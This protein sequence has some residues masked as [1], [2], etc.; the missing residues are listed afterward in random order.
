MCSI[1]SRMGFDMLMLVIL[2]FF[3]PSLVW[4]Y[5][6]N[7]TLVPCSTVP[8]IINS[9]CS[10]QMQT[11]SLSEI[12]LLRREQAPSLAD[13]FTSGGWGM[14]WCSGPVIYR[15]RRIYVQELKVLNK[16]IIIWK[17]Y[18]ILFIY[19][20]SDSTNFSYLLFSDQGVAEDCFSTS[21][22]D[23][24]SLKMNSS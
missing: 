6:L 4:R 7:L 14:D 16:C 11:I 21:F 8:S 20:F 13:C 17:V 9:L 19:L 23:T 22:L 5:Q 12:F 10:K 1:S 3:I 15:C 18:N 2:F 24:C